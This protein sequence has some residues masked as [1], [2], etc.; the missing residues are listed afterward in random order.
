MN[1]QPYPG[2][3]VPGH[4]QT[5]HTPPAHH[6]APGHHPPDHHAPGVHGGQYPP[7]DW[8]GS[9]RAA[10]PQ[11]IL[12]NLSIDL[13]Q[14]NLSSQAI[15]DYNPNNDPTLAQALQGVR[16]AIQYLNQVSQAPKQHG[17]KA[18]GGL[19][20]NAA[21]VIKNNPQDDRI[22][23]IKLDDFRPDPSK[24]VYPPAHGHHGAP[25]HPANAPVHPTTPPVYPPAH[26]TPPPVAPAPT[27]PHGTAAPPPP[28]GVPH[29]YP[30]TPPSV[31]PAAPPP[32]PPPAAHGNPPPPP[33]PHG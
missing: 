17:G 29:G 28:A 11:S 16:N 7:T 4:H 24:R 25:A 22:Y 21:V 19:Y 1:H 15:R 30:P 5:P 26:H 2:Q 3:H 31:P 27:H 32:P 14:F 12:C 13:A 8:I 18:L 20:V 9:G 10:K 6:A 33:H 23:G